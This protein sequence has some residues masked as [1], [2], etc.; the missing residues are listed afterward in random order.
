MDLKTINAKELKEKVL[1]ADLLERLGYQPVRTSGT[2]LIYLSMLRDSGTKPSFIVNKELN[3]WYDH[4]TGK[5][6]SVI[7]FGM[8][9]WQL[10]FL[11]TLR[12]ICRI[13]GLEGNVSASGHRVRRRHAVKLPHYKVEE[14]K[15][16]GSNPEITEYLTSL[17]IWHTAQNSLK[18]IYY[19][20]E[21]EKKSRKY[22]F[23]AGWQNE[24]G[25]WE[26]RNLYFKGCLG[27]RAITFIDG[28]HKR[29]AVFQGFINYLSWLTENPLAS[30]TII[31]LNTASL[32]FAA[33]KKVNEYEQVAIY[34][35][36]DS[37]GHQATIEFISEVPHAEDRSSAYTG[38][39]D[40]NDKLVS[41]LKYNS[42]KDN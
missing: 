4:G 17:G 23:A 37:I 27:H 36:H 31:V 20:V 38:Y 26:V 1:L 29:V 30:D 3:V 12:K 16:L 42:T 18:E 10:T 15:P 5:G 22:F 8:A 2:E 7:D 19:Y 34:F 41:G 39:H 21:D 24:L 13:T 25:S 33:A 9:F 32:I 28:D 40:Y 11:E 6:G 35:D 14:I